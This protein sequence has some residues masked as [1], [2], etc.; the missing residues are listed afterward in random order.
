MDDQDLIRA[1]ESQS[2]SAWGGN[3]PSPSLD[4]PFANPF[5]NPFA[6]DSTPFA[7]GYDNAPSVQDVGPYVAK[8]Q[9]TTDYASS[10][11]PESQDAGFSDLITPQTPAH[12]QYPDFG[13]SDPL[14]TELGASSPMNNHHV[15]ETSSPAR[16][17]PSSDI[18]GLLDDQ[19][20]SMNLKKAFVPSHVKRTST[21]TKSGSNQTT[22]GSPSRASSIQRGKLSRKKVGISF[23]NVLK[24]REQ[25]EKEERTRIEQEKAEREKRSSEAPTV[26]PKEVNSTSPNDSK[27]AEAASAR[28]NTANV[29]DSS[30]DPTATK[31]PTQLPLPDSRTASPSPPT[32][33]TNERVSDPAPVGDSVPTAGP[34]RS[35]PDSSALVTSSL[36]LDHAPSSIDQQFA[37]LAVTGTHFQP[38]TTRSRDTPKETESSSQRTRWG[39]TFE[40]SSPVMR[41]QSIADEQPPSAG[42]DGWSTAAHDSPLAADPPTMGY[43]NGSSSSPW[44]NDQTHPSQLNDQYTVLGQ[45]NRPETIVTETVSLD[46]VPQ[47]PI[48]RWLI[49]GASNPG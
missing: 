27:G 1:L 44:N 28:K 31:D 14:L 42:I 21:E 25:R 38:I 30:E 6:S 48:V 36:P 39:R 33:E 41:V 46:R 15:A 8:L 37:E 16:T 24:E 13:R 9:E 45:G 10:P 49:Y 2:T 47:W 34:S 23:D 22:A 17:K 43:M 7:S 4:D 18:L 12:H 26:E 32:L 19:D 5:A 20:S 3:E 11:Y 40:E 29:T 35:H